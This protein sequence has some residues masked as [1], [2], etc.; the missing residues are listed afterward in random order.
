TWTGTCVTAA[1]EN[2]SKKIVTVPA[3]KATCTVELVVAAAGTTS[4]KTTVTITGA[5]APGRNCFSCHNAGGQTTQATFEA[6]GHKTNPCTAC[7]TAVTTL[8]APHY[9]VAD[10]FACATC[11]N[12][13]NN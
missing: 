12:S 3:D 6:S 2:N 7:H 11:H 8:G 4:A 1:G 13:T 5:A 10:N 9:K